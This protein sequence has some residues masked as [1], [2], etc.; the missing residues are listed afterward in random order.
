[1]EEPAQNTNNK[2]NITLRRKDNK[3][4]QLLK[5]KVNWTVLNIRTA[6]P[7]TVRKGDATNFL[8]T[9]YVSINSQTYLQCKAYNMPVSTE[10]MLLTD[11]FQSESIRQLRT[12]FLWK[13][14]VP[15]PK[16]TLWGQSYT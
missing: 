15:T 5:K 3:Y 11:H 13:S 8:K 12:P 9:R 6:K 2:N 16:P 1:M 4:I 14:G 7:Q 10:P